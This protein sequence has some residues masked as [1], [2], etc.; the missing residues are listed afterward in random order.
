MKP[1]YLIAGI[2]L[3]LYLNR[4]GWKFCPCKQGLIPDPGPIGVQ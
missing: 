3:F 4:T 1:I 2:L